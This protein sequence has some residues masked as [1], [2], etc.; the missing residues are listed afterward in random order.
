MTLFA[1]GFLFIS[2]FT[3]FVG[4]A[5]VIFVGFD[6][7]ASDNPRSIAKITGSFPIVR[8]INTNTIETVNQAGLIQQWQIIVGDE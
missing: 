5:A 8:R 6:A 1:V 2:L 7:D 3:V 4:V